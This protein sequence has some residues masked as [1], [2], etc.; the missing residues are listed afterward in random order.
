M[1]IIVGLLYMFVGILIGFFIAIDRAV[2]SPELEARLDELRE[3]RYEAD[4]AKT[5]FHIAKMYDRV[6]K[7][8]LT[9]L[10]DEF[11]RNVKDEIKKQ[12]EEREAQD[13]N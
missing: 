10:I 3:I 12:K 13:G 4:K 2:K 8:L 5:I 7:S 9:D 11:H 6:N 1:M